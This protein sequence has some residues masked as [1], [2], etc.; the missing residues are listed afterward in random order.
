[1]KLCSLQV[2]IKEEEKYSWV[3]LNQLNVL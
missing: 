2:D 1:V 3:F